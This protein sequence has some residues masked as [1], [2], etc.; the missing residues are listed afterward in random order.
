MS[1]FVGH[2]VYLWFFIN[3]EYSSFYDWLKSKNPLIADER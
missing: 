3:E 1:C 2:P